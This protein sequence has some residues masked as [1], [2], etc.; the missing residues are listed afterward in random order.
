MYE[1]RVSSTMKLHCLST[2]FKGIISLKPAMT[3]YLNPALTSS[4][5]CTSSRNNWLI[6]DT[7]IRDIIFL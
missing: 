5:I 1:Y 4:I 3:F 6:N 7:S 2:S